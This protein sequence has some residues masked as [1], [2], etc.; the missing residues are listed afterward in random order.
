[1]HGPRDHGPRRRLLGDRDRPR[2]RAVHHLVQALEKGDG[3]E[4]LAPSEHV[5]NP[6]A[7]LARIVAVDHG[8]DGVHAQPVHVI[9]LEPEQGVAQEEVRH[10]APAEIEHARA[11]VGML[12]LARIGVLVEVGAVK[13]REAMRVLGEVG[14][15]PVEEHPD[16][17]PVQT[18]DER[19]EV[20]GPAIAARGRVVPDGLIP[21]RAIEGMLHDREELHVGEGHFGRVVRQLVAQLLIGEEPVAFLRHPPPGAQMHFVDAHGRIEGLAPSA[22]GE[23]GAVAPG[24]AVE[25][26]H[27]RR[28]A[29]LVRLE[30]E[31]IG[32]ALQGEGRPGAGHDLELVA[33]ALGHAGQEELP[34]AVARMKPQGMAAPVPAVPVADHGDALRIG[35]PHRE[36]DP[37]HA[38]ERR[39][40]RPQLVVDP[41]VGALPE[42]V[43]IEAR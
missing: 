4:V 8:G 10:L 7:G 2:M 34:D 3:L 26:L 41:V 29:R 6:L 35:R 18:I 11:P 9:P 16:S 43:E 19:H 39:G 14:G 17:A 38:F 5:G 21:P 24:E 40:M 22:L 37:H 20:V 36:D 30:A 23:P 28:R 33:R 31:G 1:M 13:V 27:D 12:A 32:I 15:D 42:E 25:P